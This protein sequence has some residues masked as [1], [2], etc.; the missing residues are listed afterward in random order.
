[1]KAA[2]AWTLIAPALAGCATMHQRR[3]GINE[4]E[5]RL[6]PLFT[7]AAVEEIAGL[8]PQLATP[9]RLGIAPP[10]EVSLGR[11]LPYGD[12]G[13]RDQERR[14]RF[15]TWS[16]VDEQRLRGWCARFRELGWIE[17][18]VFLPGALVGSSQAPADELLLQIRTAAARNH[19]DAVLITQT[20]DS[21]SGTPN[22]LALLDLTLVGMLIF[23]GHDLRA[24]MVVEGLV[25]DTRNEY[26]YASARGAHEAR[27]AAQAA[28]ID[29]RADEL[30][31][32]ARA[33]A[34]DE[35]GQALL[36][37]CLRAVPAA[38]RAGTAR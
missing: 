16:E 24:Q 13:Q 29:D 35:V 31:A 25:V 18:V 5:E 12:A 1:M 22:L 4:L 27:G 21:A 11:D 7:D 34:I 30:L 15:G 38:L 2:I 9:F 33:A 3:V 32:E 19:V 20:I 37:D 10:L 8:E 17:D 14:A 28:R 6:A 36:D 23:P 26:L